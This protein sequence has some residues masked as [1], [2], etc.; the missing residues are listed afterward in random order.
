MSKGRI[1]IGTS[2]W[3]YKHWIGTFYPEGTKESEQLG[4]Y[5]E[6]F[7]TVELN[8][9]F[10]HLPAAETFK[11]WK[12][13]VPGDFL[14]AVKASRYI[15]HMKKLKDGKAAIEQFL[16]H[17]DAL[18]KKLGVVLFQLPPGW[19]V[20]VERFEDF[21]SQLP[22]GY[23]YVFEFRNE[24]WYDEKI[25]A[26]LRKFNCAFCIY[27]LEHHRS[28]EEVTADFVYVRLHGPGAKYQGSYTARALGN[29]AKKCRAWQA[30]GRDVFVYFDNDQRGYAAFNA[31]DLLRRL[32]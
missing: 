16:G 15:T 17:A 28:P 11:H 19:K 4:Y 23:R 13:A 32:Q 14:F 7:K 29:W 30:E 8:N 10:Y 9:S 26:L 22:K 6:H 21:L 3:H 20:N 12:E 31:A 5:I 25:Y 27:E 2:G 24:T 18:G 1:H